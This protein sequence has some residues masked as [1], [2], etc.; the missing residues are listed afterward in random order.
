MGCETEEGNGG[1]EGMGDAAR[2][3]SRGGKESKRRARFLPPPPT[4]AATALACGNSRQLTGAVGF[5]GRTGGW[6]QRE[7]WIAFLIIYRRAAGK[8]V[9]GKWI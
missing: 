8:I 3:S 4:R 9:K 6:R 7:M 2:K 5:A 1:M